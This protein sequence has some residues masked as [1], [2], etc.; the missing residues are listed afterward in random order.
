MMFD[1]PRRHVPTEKRSMAMHQCSIANLQQLAQTLPTLGSKNVQ[2]STDAD[3]TPTL[4]N[5]NTHT[6]SSTIAH[7]V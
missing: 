6:T 3:T 5:N 1:W 7:H 4:V 2:E